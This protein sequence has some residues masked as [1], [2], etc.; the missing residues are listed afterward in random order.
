MQG[1]KIQV[2]IITHQPQMAPKRKPQDSGKR[3]TSFSKKVKREARL[4][5]PCTC[6]LPS[7]S[8]NKYSRKDG[9]YHAAPSLTESRFSK[10]P[11]TPFNTFMSKKNVHQPLELARCLAEH[12]RSVKLFRNRT[13]DQ[14]EAIRQW[15]FLR[16]TVLDRKPTED[17]MRDALSFLSRIF[18]FNALQTIDVKVIH[19]FEMHRLDQKN[20]YGAT[21]NPE[22]F[23]PK[24]PNKPKKPK[25]SSGELSDGKKELEYDGTYGSEFPIELYPE[26]CLDPQN[27]KHDLVTGNTPFLTMCGVLLH[28]MA[29]AFLLLYSCKYGGGWG[30]NSNCDPDFPCKRF[31]ADN[32]G[33]SKH[34]RAWHMVVTALEDTIPS[35]LSSRLELWAEEDTILAIRDGW[36]ISQCDMDKFFSENEMTEAV[37]WDIANQQ[38]KEEEWDDNLSEPKGSSAEASESEP[39]E[40]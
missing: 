20:I 16:V 39:M 31:E 1:A 34:G 37:K 40:E 24:D 19:T 22:V 36:K 8:L 18:M 32:M 15:N 33:K 12:I 21:I 30:V 17:N 13:D 6:N 3:K 2:S 14:H 4:A 35:V 29:H 26:F 7:C 28:E 10:D 25:G 23:V 11:P 9:Q 5:S 27:T 38:R